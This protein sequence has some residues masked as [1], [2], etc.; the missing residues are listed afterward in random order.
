M[1]L[2][3][4]VKPEHEIRGRNLVFCE[5]FINFFDGSLNWVFVLH[6]NVYLF[7]KVREILNFM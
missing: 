5:M 4:V 6:F 3:E 7:I 2:I 1:Y